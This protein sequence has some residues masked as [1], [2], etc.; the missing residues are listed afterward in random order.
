MKCVPNYISK[1][2]SYKETVTLLLEFVNAITYFSSGYINLKQT[3]VLNEVILLSL[4]AF[5][6][7]AVNFTTREIEEE[8]F[9]DLI[10]IMD[11]GQG[12]L[13]FW[14]LSFHARVLSL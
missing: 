13:N 7:N 4:Q 6:A 12:F 10:F 3:V 9:S 11:I 1:L 5:S 2:C 8:N 14:C